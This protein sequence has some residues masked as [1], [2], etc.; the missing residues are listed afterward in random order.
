M[1]A[2]ATRGSTQAKTAYD[3]AFI[4]RPPVEQLQQGLWRVSGYPEARTVLLAETIQAGFKADL[5]WKMPAY[6]RKPILFQDG[7]E[8]LEQRR[9]TARYFTPATTH[10]RYVAVMERCADTVVAELQAAGRADLGVLSSRMAVTVA[11]EIVGLTEGSIAHISRHLSAILTADISFGLSPRQILSYATVQ[12]H[13]AQFFLFD[14]RPAIKARRAAPREDV[15]SHLLGKGYRDTEILTEC[16]MYGAAGMVTT[17]EFIAVAAW[18][19]LQRPELRELMLHGDQE[20]RYRFLHETLR[21]EPVVGHIMR[22]VVAPLELPTA[23]G[24]VQIPAGSLIDLDVVAI[25]ADPRVAGAEPLQLVAERDLAKGTP[26]SLMSFGAGTH[27]CPGEFVAIAETDVFLRRLLALPG[28]RIEREPTVS[29]NTG[30]SSYELH[31]F[32]VALDPQAA[33]PASAA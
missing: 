6:M 33:S 27:R 13:L 7:P 14:V 29:I 16:I 30:L 15:I 19:C 22:R 32:T 20:A 24:P 1:T 12:Y 8:H 23:E 2:S 11:A 10:Q 28:L 3:T 5:I 4:G 17:Q 21:L 25:N 31:G 18:H 26:G 9:Q